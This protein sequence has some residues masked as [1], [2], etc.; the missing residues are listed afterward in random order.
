MISVNRSLLLPISFLLISASLSA[1]IDTNALKKFVPSLNR[2]LFHGYIDAEQKNILKSDG[3]ADNK[4]TLSSDDDI[5]FLLTKAA[6]TQI[7]WLQY[8]IEKDSLLSHNKKV[9]YLRGLAGLLKDLQKE[10]KAKLI[11]PLNFP[12]TVEAFDVCMQLD[13]KGLTIENYVTNLDYD[14]ALPIVNAAGFDENPGLKNSRNEL[15]RKYCLLHPE[16]TFITLTHSPDVS[17]ADS[18]VRL[19]A[20][21]YPAQLYNYAQA[22]NKLGYIIRNITDDVFIKSIVQMAKSKSGQQY[23]P[24]LDN[25]INDRITIAQIDAVKDDSIKYYKLL[26][27]TQMEY[28]ERSLNKD[29]A[30][31]FASLTGKLENKAQSV[32][33]NTING[34]H[35]VSDPSVRFKV[36]QSLNAQE[37]YYLAVLSDGIIYTSSFVKGVY[38][39]MMKK[40]NQHGD[41]LLAM[42][43]FDKYRKFIKMAAGYNTL[44]NFLSTFPKSKNP[45]ED[46]PANILMKAFVGRLEKSV[47]LEDGVDV[48]DSYASIQET[49]HPLANE[50]LNNIQLN[51]QRNISQR[52]MRGVAIYNILNK[53]FLSAD[54]VNHIDLTME[55]GIQPVYEVPF[56]A[57]ANDSGRVIIQ[58]FNYGDN[59][60][61]GV[62]PWL[63]NLFSNSKWNIDRRN[64]QCV[65][66]KSAKVKPVSL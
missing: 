9:Y 32:F 62:F 6:T 20:K 15:L 50:M 3:K 14:V 37:L 60:G 44:S 26:V 8:K 10:W 42:L 25:I 5:N 48:A 59:D 53:L 52:N 46:D 66:I 40:I 64:P 1:Q 38:P 55:L 27:K 19:V 65:T 49:L 34:L 7:D 57:L 11:N 45:N 35:T 17:F 39:L 58:L 51:Y 28:V 4:F 18:L 63:L 13:K 43:R 29:T 2:Q 33:V 30:F 47:G 24:F 31:E 21:K 36:I 41:S 16:K 22:N 23:F 61:I 56:K 54:T 12:A